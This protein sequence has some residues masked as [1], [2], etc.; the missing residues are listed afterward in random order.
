MTSTMRELIGEHVDELD[1]IRLHQR[2]EEEI[3]FEYC[4][5]K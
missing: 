5:I 3:S 2:H 1:D 4:S